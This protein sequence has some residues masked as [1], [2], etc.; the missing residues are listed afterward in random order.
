MT[1][2]DN[3][4]KEWSWCKS[5]VPG[6]QDGLT[7]YLFPS[8]GAFRV[9]GFFHLCFPNHQTT[10]PIKYRLHIDR[11]QS[12]FGVV[13]LVKYERDSKMLCL[14]LLNLKSLQFWYC[15]MKRRHLWSQVM[16]T[17]RNWTKA[18]ALKGRLTE[19]KILVT[20]INAPLV[21]RRY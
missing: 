1:T 19:T 5:I 20:I 17:R 12:N 3:T 8:V 14:Y 21:Y 18:G 7:K 10:L 4:S 11:R 15:L 16:T 13:I 6:H 9:C 2:L